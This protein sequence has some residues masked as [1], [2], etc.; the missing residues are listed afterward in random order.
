MRIN[1]KPLIVIIGICIVSTAVS[2]CSG[3]DSPIGTSTSINSPTQI[4]TATPIKSPTQTS[5]ATPIQSPTQTPKATPIQSRAQPNSPNPTS[6]PLVISNRPQLESGA[7]NSRVDVAALIQEAKGSPQILSCLMDTIGMSTLMELT[8]RIPT[9]QE[10]ELILSCFDEQSTSSA[11]S[12]T[13][14]QSPVVLV[15]PED[16]GAN[17]I[18]KLGDELSGWEG[19][20]IRPHAG[21]FIWGLIEPKPGRYAWT[22]TTDRQVER[23]QNENLAVLVTIWPFA[24]WDQDLCHSDEPEAVGMFPG[25]GSRLYSPCNKEA[26]SRWLT[27]AV[28]RYDGDGID[29]MPGLKYPIRHWE[30]LNE[31]EMQG[32]ELTFYQEDSNFYLELLKLSYQAIKA[33]D[34]NSLVLL[35]GQAG[36]QS[37]F[38]DYWQPILQGAAGYFDVGNIHS[39]SGSDLDFFASEYRGFLDDNKFEKTSF[40]V[41]E[42]L[43]GTPPGE[44]K[45]TD[46]ELARRTMISYAS[47]FAAGA[48][49]IFNVGGHDP[50]GGPGELS[51]KT[52]QL[53][54]QVFGK[55]DTVSQLDDN[56]VEFEMPDGSSVFVLWDNAVLPPMV[57]GKITVI[58]YLGNEDI[59][60]A[61]EVSGSSPRMAI[62]DSR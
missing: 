4:P 6:T 27:A 44:Q 41:T 52:V 23:W 16:V 33:A 14:P 15:W 62:V 43:I 42:A 24:S 55:F 1:L 5:T 57:S 47:S 54:A 9:P 61:I 13:K 12:T 35:G 17:H 49:Y 56:L 37:K 46:D 45:L 18:G 11:T 7:G 20:W 48:D 30:V 22:F 50:T 39:I 28:E 2:A 26:Y 34:S 29:D 21:R 60:E 51:A 3:T 32:P 36:M 58:D 19:G 8:N 59:E 53:M 10:S 38:V 40:W 25:M 31:P